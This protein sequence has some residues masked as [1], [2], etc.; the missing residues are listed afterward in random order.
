MLRE[1]WKAMFT[2]RAATAR[3]IMIVDQCLVL[4]APTWGD[5][6]IVRYNTQHIINTVN[7][8]TGATTITRLRF[9]VLRQQ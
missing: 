3:P 1:Q 9:K 7:T 4:A 5:V 2:G 8:L 6:Q